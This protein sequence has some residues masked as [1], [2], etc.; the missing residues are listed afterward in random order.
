[1][2]TSKQQNSVINVHHI[3]PLLCVYVGV[4][5]GVYVCILIFLSELSNDPL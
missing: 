4:Y 5:K 2:I 1:M 3:D